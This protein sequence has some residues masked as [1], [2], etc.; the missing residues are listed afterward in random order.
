MTRSNPRLTTRYTSKLRI[1]LALLIVVCLLLIPST[2]FL[3][4]SR[5]WS[6]TPN[7]DVRMGHPRPGKP[8]GIF[9]DLDTVRRETSAVREP[10]LP[11]PST[12]RAKRNIGKPWDGRRVGDPFDQPPAQSPGGQ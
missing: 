12:V 2:P 1:T 6:V 10:A 4:R 7:Q 5:A 3:I 11:I 9:P 8:E